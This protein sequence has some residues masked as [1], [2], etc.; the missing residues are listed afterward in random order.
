MAAVQR[1]MTVFE[2]IYILLNPCRKNFFFQAMKFE[3]KRQ[4][5]RKTK[6]LGE[7]PS[8]AWAALI[9]AHIT[10]THLFLCECIL[11]V[12]RW[13]NRSEHAPDDKLQ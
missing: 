12:W 3:L 8:G 5:K 4:P 13:M 7:K 2:K 1:C 10:P 9:S 6:L 11:A